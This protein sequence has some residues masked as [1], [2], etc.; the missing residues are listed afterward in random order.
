MGIEGAAAAV[1]LRIDG[2]NFA[3]AV[4]E[5]AAG[6]AGVNRRIGL[7][8]R[9]IIAARQ[10]A[11][12]C[13][14]NALRRGVREAE[15]RADGQYPVADLHLIGIAEFGDGQVF[16]LDFYQRNIGAFVQ[17]DDFGAVFLV[18]VELHA[19]LV[20]PFDNVGIG[21]DVAVA[22]DDEAG[23]LPFQHTLPGCILLKG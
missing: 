6:I 10:V 19:H 9:Y 4:E 1:N 17:T 8:E 2:D 13:A 15:G 5:R 22:I 21:Q 3:F 11:G 14:D 16:A 7:D 23:T 18:V 12:D 20:R